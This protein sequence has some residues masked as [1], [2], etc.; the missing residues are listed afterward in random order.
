V[1]SVSVAA[2]AAPA[3]AVGSETLKVK[4]NFVTAIFFDKQSLK[5]L[6]FTHLSLQKNDSD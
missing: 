1:Q 5:T 2:V 6:Y 3:I 4:K